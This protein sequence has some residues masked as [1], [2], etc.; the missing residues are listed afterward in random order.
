MVHFIL[1]PQGNS[2]DVKGSSIWKDGGGGGADSRAGW[3]AHRR[4]AHKFF[5]QKGKAQS[6]CRLKNRKNFSRRSQTRL[7]RIQRR[8]PGDHLNSDF[9]GSSTGN[10]WFWHSFST[11]ISRFLSRCP[12][13]SIAPAATRGPI[14]R[15]ERFPVLHLSEMTFPHRSNHYKGASRRHGNSYGG[16]GR[17]AKCI[18]RRVKCTVQPDLCAAQSHVRC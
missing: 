17:Q 11:A 3:G 13:T 7:S 10:P 16:T 9:K 5:L 14:I 6:S 2:E 8:G 15:R 4:E 12:G 1:V 18:P